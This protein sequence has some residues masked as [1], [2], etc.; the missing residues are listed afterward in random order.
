MS[1]EQKVHVV[2]KICCQW[3]M[4]GSRDFGSGHVVGESRE[5]M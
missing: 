3:L 1:L 2:L 4:D 5:E